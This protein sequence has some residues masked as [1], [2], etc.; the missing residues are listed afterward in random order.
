MN[1]FISIY[2]IILPNIWISYLCIFGW[3]ILLIYSFLLDIKILRGRGFIKKKNGKFE[4]PFLMIPRFIL[5]VILHI[6][7]S[8]FSLPAL[9]KIFDYNYFWIPW[10]FMLF[11][12]I[13]LHTIL[14]GTPNR[15]ILMGVHTSR[16][17]IQIE[18][19]DKI[20]RRLDRIFGK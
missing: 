7:L 8:V 6:F 14:L 15:S 2:E 9:V 5:I 20:G 4:S 3:F 17:Y 18:F 19:A 12:Q 1:I 10:V 11:S 13:L 16:F